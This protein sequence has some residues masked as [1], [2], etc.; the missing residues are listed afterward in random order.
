M[1]GM[2]TMYITGN[3]ATFP[4][5]VPPWQWTQDTCTV[6]HLWTRFQL[7]FWALAMDGDTVWT[8]QR[9]R[10]QKATPVI[11]GSIRTR[12]FLQQSRQQ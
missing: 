10:D 5:K 4:D 6:A 3:S 2:N 12:I 7:W 8:R 11:F 9:N 1:M